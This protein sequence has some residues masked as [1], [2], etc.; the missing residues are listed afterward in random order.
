MTQRWRK[1]CWVSESCC[2]CCVCHVRGHVTCRGDC[3]VLLLRCSSAAADAARAMWHART[4][5]NWRSSVIATVALTICQSVSQSHLTSCT[6]DD[7]DDITVAAAA[8]AAAVTSANCRYTWCRQNAITWPASHLLAHLNSFY[9]SL[10]SPSLPP[11]TRCPRCRLRPSLDD[12]L[13]PVFI[14]VI[15]TVLGSRD[16]RVTSSDR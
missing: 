8:A 6:D 13:V 9:S 3:D 12:L 1:H 14:I 4:G 7:D 10:P 11:H 2:S 5:T 15:V 16:T